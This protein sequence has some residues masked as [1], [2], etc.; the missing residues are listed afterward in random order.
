M[1]ALNYVDADS[2]I[3]RLNPLTRLFLAVMLCLG[4]IIT[5]SV[6]TQ[7][8]Y[9]LFIFAIARIARVHPNAISLFKGLFKACLFIFVLQILFVRRG[10]PLFLFITDEGLTSAYIVAM[11]V[12]NASLAF[13]L[14]LMVT[15][16]TDLTNAMVYY[17]HLSYRYAF[18]ITTAL[19]FI[20][21]LMD[22]LNE[23]REAQTARGVEFDTGSSLK[24]L[25]LILPL[26]APLLINAIRRTDS[27]AVSAEVR[28]FHLRTRLSGCK[29]YPFRTCDLVCAAACILLCVLCVLGNI[30]LKPLP[31]FI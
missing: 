7:T 16:M 21:I 28:G 18:V 13:T 26:C 15:R 19:R 27:A 1:G 10:N 25:Q 23:I 31:F 2:P 9:L 17:L 14:V 11:R 4:S 30:Y 22:E 5:D 20:P 24:R 12:M 6:I 8:L 3:H 29:V